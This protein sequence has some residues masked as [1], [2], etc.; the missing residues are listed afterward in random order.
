[1]VVIQLVELQIYTFLCLNISLNHSCAS[2]LQRTVYTIGL[3]LRIKNH[4]ETQCDDHRHHTEV[5]ATKCV[6]LYCDFKR[7][8]VFSKI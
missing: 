8:S 2:S 3:Q 1:M 6:F 7:I 4:H 5:I